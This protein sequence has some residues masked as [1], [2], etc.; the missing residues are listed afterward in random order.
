MRRAFTLIELLV[1]IAIIALLITMVVVGIGRVHKS[2]KG[3][4]ERQTVAGMNQ[5]V[6]SFKQTFGF[7][8]PLVPSSDDA[9]MKVQPVILSPSGVVVNAY[10]G[11]GDSTN[12]FN[13][14]TVFLEGFN[15]ADA[16]TSGVRPMSGDWAYGTDGFASTSP[17]F[18]FSEYSL[19]YFLVG[20]LARGIDGVDGPGMYRPNSDGT[21]DFG[22]GSNSTRVNKVTGQTF[23]SLVDTSRS[24]PK[25]DLDTTAND[26]NLTTTDPATGQQVSQRTRYR[27]LSP[28]GQPYRYY[29][30][31]A[32]KNG[33]FKSTP[34]FSETTNKFDR[35]EDGVDLLN[36]PSVLG[37]P[38]T[39]ANLR[40]AEYAIVSAGPD[41]YFGDMN[42]EASTQDKYDAMVAN[43]KVG[44][45]PSNPSA[46]CVKVRK[47]ARADNIVEVGR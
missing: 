5:A 34:Y 24:F 11:L 33:P 39:D 4:A 8:P 17:D 36:V 25:L 32:R 12:S 1:S 18:R 40:G 2:A 47:A 21:F 3:A 10:G 37:D 38:R 28:S 16:R 29:R 42:L 13:S 45:D 19:A 30:W 43:L 46:S 20:A 7:L 41:G 23:P 14:N 9:T 44:I 15:G 26:G 35:V 6:Q 27:L 22:K 31:T